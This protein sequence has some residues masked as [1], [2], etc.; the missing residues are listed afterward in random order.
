MHYVENNI[1]SYIL[2]CQGSIYWG[3]GGGGGV[4][5]GG[6]M[7]KYDHFQYRLRN[8]SYTCPKVG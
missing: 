5:E 1:L 3:G 4:E 7:T 2:A 8:N 6:L